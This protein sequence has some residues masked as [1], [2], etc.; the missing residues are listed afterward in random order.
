MATM[1][2]D[3]LRI[4]GARRIGV[5]R[6]ALTGGLASSAFFALCWAGAFL[7]IGPATHMYLRLFT[8]ADIST[9]RALIEGACWA[10]AFG[11]VAGALIAVIYNALGWLDRR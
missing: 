9:A 2:S 11:L 3:D 7:P 5:F 4:S 10:A 8:A 6:L 1:T